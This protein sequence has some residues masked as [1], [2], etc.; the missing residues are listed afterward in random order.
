[1]KASLP[2]GPASGAGDCRERPLTDKELGFK[3]PARAWFYVLREAELKGE[4]R[5][6]RL[7]PVS[8]RIVAEVL[9]GLL[10]FH[11]SRTSTSNLTG[12]RRRTSS[13]DGPVRSMADLIRF[14]TP[15]QAQRF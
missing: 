8:G 12:R 11:R 1:M 10:A 2:S 3:G 14:A 15:D 5:G 6:Q 4:L 13:E 9:L 7:G